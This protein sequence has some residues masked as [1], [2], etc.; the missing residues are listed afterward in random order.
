MRHP[1]E[2]LIVLQRRPARRAGAAVARLVGWVVRKDGWND[3]DNGDKVFEALARTT[4]SFAIYTLV[5]NHRRDCAVPNV[6]KCHQ[7]S[8]APP[9][10]FAP[11]PRTLH[12]Y[13]PAQSHHQAASS[14]IIDSRMI[15][16][17]LSSG[18]GGTVEI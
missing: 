11:V 6:P 13:K 2:L 9:T 14:L 10:H 7:R 1:F 12:P 16:K 4:Q 5:F 3:G 17:K 8:A 18:K 15:F